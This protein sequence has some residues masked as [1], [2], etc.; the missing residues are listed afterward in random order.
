MTQT[1]LHV[2]NY[3]LEKQTARRENIVILKRKAGGKNT[4]GQVV[5]EGLRCIV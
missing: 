1:T 4:L 3:A 2:S 5:F